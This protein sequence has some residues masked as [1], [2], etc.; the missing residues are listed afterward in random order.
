MQTGAIDFV[1]LT[2]ENLRA[3]LD[4]LYVAF[5]PHE[6]VCTAVGLS[7][8]QEAMKELEELSANTAHDGVSI[9]AIE[10]N[11][12]AIVGVAFNKL[13]VSINLFIQ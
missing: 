1:S 12:G 6:N 3:A 9:V 7:K 13:Q 11:S 5:F 2:K 4:L 8:N 10:K